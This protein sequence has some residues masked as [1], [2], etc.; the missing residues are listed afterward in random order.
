MD[1]QDILRLCRDCAASIYGTAPPSPQ[2]AE[3]V[4]KLLFMT[5]AHESLAFR[6]RRQIGFRR[7]TCTGAFGLWQ[8]E[9]ASIEASIDLIHRPDR[10]PLR[11]RCLAW[12]DRWPGLEDVDLSHRTLGIALLALQ[13]PRGDPLSCLLA[14]LHYLR[15]P[16]AVP[17]TVQDM[18]VYAKR[19]YNTRLGKATAANYLSAYEKWWK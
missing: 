16:E 9:L 6:F 5:A 19:Y 8:C 17:A 3:R 10:R 18:A 7:E 14:R 12:L 1:K 2:Y 4:A 13:E 11:D 15:V